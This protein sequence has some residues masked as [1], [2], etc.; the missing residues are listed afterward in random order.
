MRDTLD[1]WL[2]SQ[3]LHATDD[4]DV[5]QLLI[6]LRLLLTTS[7]NFYYYAVTAVLAIITTITST[8]VTTTPAPLP[9]REL[10]EVLSVRE[11]TTDKGKVSC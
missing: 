9:A 8:I 5:L 1:N 7:N 10:S 6:L 2:I 3:Y 4:I 11:Y